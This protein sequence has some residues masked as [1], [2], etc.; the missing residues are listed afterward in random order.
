[1]EQ[2]INIQK[3]KLDDIAPAN[4]NPRIELNEND[5][6]YDKIKNSIEQFGY[7][8]PIIYNKRTNTI[9]GGHQRY[10]VLRD[11]GYEEVDVSVVDMDE[12]DEMALNVALNK[13]EGEWDKDKLKDVIEQL[14]ED[15]LVFTG[16]DDDEIDS[17]MNDV[18]IDEFFE[19][20]EKQ[21]EQ[22]NDDGESRLEVATEL[23]EL[24]HSKLKDTS[25][26]YKSTDLYQS[27]EYFLEGD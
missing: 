1:M 24:V 10:T 23:L 12:Q 22:N 5:P 20:E 16:F 18:N 27:V 19:E 15:K 7:V 2:T 25:D 6:E 21:P 14:E 26:D 17:L 3:M 11:L 8:D 4:Y 13:V 9:V